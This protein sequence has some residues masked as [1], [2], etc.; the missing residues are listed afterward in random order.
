[1][2]AG[3]IRPRRALLADLMLALLTGVAVAAG[4]TVMGAPLL[5]HG[6]FALGV[7]LGGLLLARR[8]RPLLVLVVSAV[9]LIGYQSSGLFEGGWIWPLSAAL[10]T[11]ALARPG[12]AAG[13]GALT[14]A[15]GLS[16]QGLDTPEVL[17]RGG[18]ELLW[19]ALVLAAASATRQYGRW[20]AEHRARLAQL[21]QTRLAEQRLHISREVHDVVAHTLAVVGV[22]LNVAVAALD[23]SPEEAQ[24]A[25]RTAIDV[26]NQAMRDLKAFVGELRDTPQQGVESIADLVAQARAA[27]LEVRYEPEGDLAA[28]PAAQAL[29]AYRVVQEAVINTLRHSDADNL[30]IQVQAGAR[31]LVVRVADDGNTTAGY[32]AGHGLTGM[33]E[34]V[35]VIGGTLDIDADAGGFAVRAVLPLTAHMSGLAS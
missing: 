27:G 14:L 11:A 22:H 12:W 6:A 9:V 24:A 5:W 8:R 34:R 1:M 32:T 25:L 7:L 15:Y 35:T 3:T 17:A 13:V 10:F 4:A 31:D 33:R 20:R 23:D 16:R 26:R 21:E 29:T 18:V 19:L 2:S 30:T 28:V